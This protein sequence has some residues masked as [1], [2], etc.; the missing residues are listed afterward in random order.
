MKLQ[1][2]TKKSD[3]E[4]VETFSIFSDYVE[5]SCACLVLIEGASSGHSQDGL[6][7]KNWWIKKHKHWLNTPD[8]PEIVEPVITVAVEP[9]IVPVVK[10]SKSLLREY[11]VPFAVGSAVIVS[12][13]AL[14]TMYRRSRH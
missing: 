12:G 1:T 6:K 8:K 5:Q 14:L 3:I 11:A 10:T 13:I 4:T 7:L 2:S 9:E